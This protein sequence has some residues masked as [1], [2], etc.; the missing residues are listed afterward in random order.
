MDK[1]NG[2]RGFLDVFSTLYPRIQEV[3]FRDDVLSLEVP[4]YVIMG[5]YE[6]R[7]REIPAREW[8]ELLEAPTKE[9]VEFDNSGHR[10]HFEE[11]AKFSSLMKQIANETYRSG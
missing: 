10:P 4:V 7:G 2:M 8:F 11:P 3:D 6:A 1:I 5:R 9:L